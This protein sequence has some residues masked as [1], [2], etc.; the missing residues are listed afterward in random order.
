MSNR[1]SW[2]AGNSIGGVK[3]YVVQLL[4][5]LFSLKEGGRF[6]GIELANRILA[7]DS[8]CFHQFRRRIH[9]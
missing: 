6:F 5:D 9:Y 8:M 3:Y 1:S 2:L 4:F 7:R